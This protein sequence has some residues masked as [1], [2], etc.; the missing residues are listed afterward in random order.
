MPEQ[1]YSGFAITSF[2]LGIVGVLIGYFLLGIP[3]L[4]AV[5]FGFIA[6]SKIKKNKKLRGKALA[7]WG[8]GLGMSFLVLVIIGIVWV[9][10]RNVVGAA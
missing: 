2:V 8:I 7:W 9:V 4:L 10:V 1:R 6:L 3:N 5:I